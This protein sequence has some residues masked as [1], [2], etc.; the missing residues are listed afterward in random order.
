MTDVSLLQPRNALVGIV[1]TS[2][3]NVRISIVD[4][5]AGLS[6]FPQVVQLMALNLTSERAE[7]P[8]NA[9][10]PISVTP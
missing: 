10:S 8:L 2:L 3:L 4:G 7:H 1:N 6:L 9:P 5:N